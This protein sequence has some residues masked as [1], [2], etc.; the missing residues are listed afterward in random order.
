MKQIAACLLVAVGIGGAV[1]CADEVLAPLAISCF[2]PFA[3]MS[4]LTSDSFQTGISKNH[5]FANLALDSARKWR[6]GHENA[7]AVSTKLLFYDQLSDV[8]IPLV[9]R[10]SFPGGTSTLRRPCI[11]D[12]FECRMLCAIQSGPVSVA[13]EQQSCD[14]FGAQ[15]PPEPT[16]HHSFDRDQKLKHI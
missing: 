4:D 3:D 8:A 14:R 2:D 5:I 13:M 9:Y 7:G 15:S 1:Y 10:G 12:L 16:I 6:T 11:R